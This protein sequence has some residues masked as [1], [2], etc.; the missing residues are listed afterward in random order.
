MS[1]KMKAALCTKPGKIEVTDADMPEPKE[2]E[3]L[4]KVK[5]TGLCGSDVDGY[6]GRHPMIGYPIIMGHEFAGVIAAMGKGVTSVREGDA[7]VGE[8]F[9]TCK[10]CQACLEGKYNLCKNLLITGHQVPGS[11][12]QYVLAE[13]LFVHS[14]PENVSFDEGA[15]AEPLSGSL[16]AVKRAGVGI[17]DFT[18]IIGCGT[19]GSFSLQHA[20]NAGAEVLIAD[21][22]D[23]KLDVARELGA[24][25]V[26]NATREDL[27]AKVD[28]LTDGVG[29]DKVIEAVG[30][31]ETLAATTTLVR[32][33]GTIMLIGWTGNKTDPFDLT[34]LTLDEL[35][36]MGT[37]GFCW[38]FP[39]ALGLV[40]RGKVR[41]DAIISHK[42]PLE[43][44]QEAIELFHSGKD[45]VWKIIITYED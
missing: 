6:L 36:V 15:I 10:K 27:K 5:A 21:T 29:A 44:T 26:L 43:K 34:S 42:Y 32:R 39:T 9:F 28:E 13:A 7:I 18:V 2:G 45:N 22:Q 19:I 41:L 25:Y 40:R 14:K 35:T 20:K 4:V 31:P 23:F 11:L 38:D 8:P 12:A 17:G 1:K 37:L 33:G 16:H 30:L 24:D 3:V